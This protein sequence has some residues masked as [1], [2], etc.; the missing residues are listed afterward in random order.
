MTICCINKYYE[1]PIRAEMGNSK[2]NREFAEGDIYKIQ[3][4]GG[5][6]NFVKNTL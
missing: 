1:L 4:F 2:C 6:L 5:I 3:D